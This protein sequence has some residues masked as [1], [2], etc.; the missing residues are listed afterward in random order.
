MLVCNKLRAKQISIAQDFTQQ[1]REEQNIMRK[2]LFMANQEKSNECYIRANKL[3]VNGGACNA[4][5]LQETNDNHTTQK[6][7]PATP[8]V[9]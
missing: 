3:V 8:T 7:A 1:Q 5:E 6:S 2:H 9:Q 4:E